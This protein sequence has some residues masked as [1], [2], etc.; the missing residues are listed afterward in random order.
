MLL[1]SGAPRATCGPKPRGTRSAA[2]RRHGQGAQVQGLEWSSPEALG[3]VTS[4]E[5]PHSMFPN[6][7][8][9]W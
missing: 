7:G 8:K 6:M 2:V 5:I 3:M 1:L 4:V 9:S